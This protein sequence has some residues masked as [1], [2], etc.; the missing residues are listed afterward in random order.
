MFQKLLL[1]LTLVVFGCNQDVQSQEQNTI[2][3]SQKPE[4]VQTQVWSGRRNAITQ[5]VELASPAVVSINVSK[6]VESVSR[7]RDPI[8][9][10]LYRRQRQQITHR[11]ITEVGSGFI[12]SA[13]GYIVTND[14]VAGGASSITVAFSDGKTFDAKLVGSDFASDLALLKIDASY[15]LPYL[16]FSEAGPPIVGEWSIAMGNPFGLFEASAPSVTVGV[17]S[18]NDRDLQLQEGRIYRD[19]IQTDAAINRGNSGGP[20]LNALGE[21]IG[22]NTAIITEGAGG[23]V[24]IGFAVPAHK[25][26]R[27]LNEIKETG[28]VD[29]SYYIGMRGRTV[30]ARDASNE[31]LERPRGVLV[32]RVDMDSPAWEAG[33]RP[34]DVIV[35]MAGGSV[36]TQEDF[37]SLL[38]DFRPGEVIPFEIIRNQRRQKLEMKLG[39]NQNI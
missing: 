31:R 2:A 20:L 13:D 4:G 24:G 8:F 14:H 3:V 18:A 11:K 16:K 19:M 23:S 6:V 37:I 27:I 1:V 36:N 30:S 22:V 10:Y 38:Y 21:V 28:R 35:S 32:V 29:R 15:D 17:V 5:A 7:Y 9:E 34:H 26:I 39:S 25:A 12:I 33:F